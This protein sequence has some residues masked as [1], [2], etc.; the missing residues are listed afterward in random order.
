MLVS[1]LCTRWQAGLQFDVICKMRHIFISGLFGCNML[2]IGFR[3]V[4]EKVY[5]GMSLV[6]SD[7]ASPWLNQRSDIQYD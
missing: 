4:A 2:F 1:E 7:N 5:N 3:S 6:R